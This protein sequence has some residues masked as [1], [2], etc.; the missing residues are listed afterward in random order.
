[1]ADG[2]KRRG[3]G[4]INP[5]GIPK[6]DAPQF[7]EG[8]NGNQPGTRYSGAAEIQSLQTGK[9]AQVRYT[10]I[11]TAYGSLYNFYNSICWLYNFGNGKFRNEN[12]RKK[13]V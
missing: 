13:T 5:L 11:G 10:E 6:I 7:G 8:G 1:M 9:L 12:G 4:V 3:R 2:G